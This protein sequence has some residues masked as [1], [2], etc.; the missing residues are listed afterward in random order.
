MLPGQILDADGSGS[1]SCEE[2]CIAMKKLV[3]AC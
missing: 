3:P 2:F 1:M